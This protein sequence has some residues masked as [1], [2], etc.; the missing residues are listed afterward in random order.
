MDHRSWLK[1]AWTVAKIELRR[2]FLSKRAFWVYGLALLPAIIFFFHGAQM[3]I[4][5]QSL[6][7][8]GFIQPALLDSVSVGETA[9]AV[10][11]RLGK[12]P[13][14]YER[15]R[16]RMV[17]PQGKASGITTHN[18]SPA[19]EARYIRLN[20]RVPSYNGDPDARIY[21]LE[22]YGEGDSANLALN[23]PATGS[24][25]CSPAE[26]PDKA[27][28]GSASD[29]W[30]S[31]ARDKYLQVD[32][33]GIQKIERVVIK[34][35]SAGGEDEQLNT[36]LFDIQ[37][38]I[39]NKRFIRIV[40]P[41]GSRFIDEITAVRTLHYSDGLREV[42]FQ[43]E[44]GK[45]VSKNIRVLMNFEEDRQIF[46][47]IF[48]FFYLRLAIFFGCVGIFMN[49]FRGEMLDRTLHFWFLAP[50]RREVL[51]AG[52]YGA[53][54]I[55]SIVIFGGGALLC[56]G[57]LLLVQNPAEVRAY[58]QVA[59]W[60]HAFWYTAA[61]ALGCVGYGS[62]FLAAG[63]LLRNP[64][65]P[66]AV[67]LG[68]EAINGFLPEILQKLS[69]LYYLQSLCPVPAPM[70]K[71]VP[72]LLQLLLKPADPASH[73]GAIFGILIVTALVLAIAVIAI[74]RMEVS[75]GSEA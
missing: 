54:L 22:V 32:L 9:E 50:A 37:A 41:T 30:C 61:A 34:H 8:G 21:E 15:S 10:I 23:R 60:A 53:G 1:Q 70:D 24:A 72:A 74:R 27:F 3:K 19:I 56:F 4:R 48:Q 7:A 18:I 6:S 36:A 49:L 5:R 66:A 73:A 29:G 62:V 65:L 39:D 43:F 55:A 75:Y 20:I 67:L 17:S 64:V 52:K 40:N 46:A 38:S 58:W 42:T 31:G 57:V 68:W 47:G 45:L 12:A 71:D 13:L 26:A 25:P 69:V 63:L 16:H 44:D 14:D 28:N 51:L 2:A 59:G 33:G 35:A 11:Q